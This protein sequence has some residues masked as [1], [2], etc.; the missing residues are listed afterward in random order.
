MTTK[1]QPQHEEIDRL[2]PLHEEV[3]E[4]DVIRC[5]DCGA[6]YPA[7]DGPAMLYSLKCPCLHCG[8]DCELA[9]IEQPLSQVA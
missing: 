8:G 6:T 9:V 3:A 7:V 5:Q 2:H 4:V 1:L